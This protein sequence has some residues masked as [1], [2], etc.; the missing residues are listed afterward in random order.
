VAG[1]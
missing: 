1:G